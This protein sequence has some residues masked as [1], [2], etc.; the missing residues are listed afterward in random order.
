MLPVFINLRNVGLT[1]FTI[2]ALTRRKQL[3]E[4][5][6]RIRLLPL[7]LPFGLFQRTADNFRLRDIPAY[8]QTLQSS[9]CLLIKRKRSAVFHGCHTISTYHHFDLA[10][11][12]QTRDPR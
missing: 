4:H 5:L 7:G 1:L 10:S 11:A 6:N 3:P 12:N 9:G 2:K 8:C